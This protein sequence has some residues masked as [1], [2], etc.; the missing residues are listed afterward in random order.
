MLKVIDLFE[1]I[2]AKSDSFSKY[3]EGK[4]AFITNGDHESSILG[5]VTPFEGDRVFDK[6]S[7]CLTSFGEALVPPI[8][9]MPRGN[10]GSGLII[11]TPKIEMNDE[12]L[13]SYASQLNL[14]KWKFNFSRM[15]IE[16]RIINL[17]LVKYSASINIEN[18]IIELLPKK[19]R[20]K[21][22]KHEDLELIQVP[23]V[24]D[25]KNQKDG[26]CV[27]SKAPSKKV[28]SQNALDNGN[29]PYVTTTSYNNGIS[30]MY[31]IDAIFDSKC[32]TLALNGSV[33]EVFF[34]FEDFTTGGDNAI[35]QIKDKYNPYLLFYIATMIRNHQW[36]YNYYRKLTMAKLKRIKIPIPFKDNEIAFD[37]IKNITKNSYGYK[38]IQPFI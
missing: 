19:G 14:Q 38:D 5:Y 24:Y 16:K 23:L 10:G 3:S 12:E 7:I 2:N 20:R 9:F 21:R 8:P 32:L 18:R 34:Q 31:D 4:V 26:L 13:Y 33:G 22:I 6:K 35:L 11:L 37:Y 17:P 36:R 15:V 1:P 28:L 30:G 29:T 27:A 25:A